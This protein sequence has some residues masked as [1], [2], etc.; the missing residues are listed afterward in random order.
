[1]AVLAGQHGHRVSDRSICTTCR[2]GRGHILAASRLQLVQ[3]V[4]YIP[5]FS[6]CLCFHALSLLFHDV[7]AVR[8]LF[9]LAALAATPINTSVS[10]PVNDSP[11]FMYILSCQN[12]CPLRLIRAFR[13]CV[14]AGD[15]VTGSSRVRCRQAEIRRKSDCSVC[16]K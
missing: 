5:S 7:T 4:I 11:K 12:N 10:R 6:V 1:M 16:V 3:Y 13:C 8:R 14:C 2:P 15:W 9:Y